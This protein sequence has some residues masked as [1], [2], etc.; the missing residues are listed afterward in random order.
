MENVKAAVDAAIPIIRVQTDDLVHA[1]PVLKHLIGVEPAAMKGWDIEKLAGNHKLYYIVGSDA[2]DITLAHAYEKLIAQERSVITINPDPKVNALIPFD[3][4]HLPVPQKML[5]EQVDVVAD[6]PEQ[7]EAI[8]LRLGGCSLKEAAELMR[9]TMVKT[10]ALTPQGLAHTRRELFQASKGLF[11]VN[12]EQD[13]YIP[14]NELMEWVLLEKPYFLEG[15]MQSLRPRG[16]L[17]DGAPGVGKSSGAKWIA[18]Q[19]GVPLYLLSVAGAQ[20]KWV[21]KSEENFEAALARAERESPCVILIDEIEKVFATASSD[22]STSM[23]SQLLWWLQEHRE[24]VLTVMTTNDRKAIPPELYRAGRIDQVMSVDL[25]SGEQITNLIAITCKAHGIKDPEPYWKAFK[26]A[27]QA[28]A[29]AKY[30]HAF[31][32]GWVK[33]LMKQNGVGL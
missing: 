17:M 28:K 23:M 18:E 7:A 16:L 20:E 1:V 26:K 3:A 33:G 24:R 27:N 15:K 11:P 13:G 22:T 8:M 25:A 12:T 30:A 31:V 10:G 5:R 19:F 2:G 14:S 4:G 32:I 29:D 6:T 21:G 9:L